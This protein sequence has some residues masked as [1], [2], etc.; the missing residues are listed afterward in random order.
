M[1]EYKT[2]D[3][4]SFDYDAATGNLSNCQYGFMSNYGYRLIAL[5]MQVM[6]QPTFEAW[7]GVIARPQNPKILQYSPKRDCKW[8]GCL[9]LATQ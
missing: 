8:M 1:T 3:E 4:V 7:D 2:M 5:E 9:R 6:M